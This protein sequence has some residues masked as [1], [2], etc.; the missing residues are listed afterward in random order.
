MVE[1]APRPHRKFIENPHPRRGLASVENLR[2]RPRHGFHKTA[3]Q[4]GDAAHALQE[5]ERRAL[6]RQ[7]RPQISA[8]FRDR[9]ALADLVAV[10]LAR[11]PDESR[12]KPAKN[13]LCHLQPGHD[14]GLLG[15]NHRARVRRFGK[16]RYGKVS[17]ADV[18]F[19]RALDDGLNVVI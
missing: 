8:Q 17:A 2:A 16:E 7:D 1:P 9:I 13:H 18:L 15:Q 11:I 19:Q 10:L 4:R 14:S 6:A 3:C 5:I 12:V